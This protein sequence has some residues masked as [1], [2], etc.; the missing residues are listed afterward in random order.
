MNVIRNALTALGAMYVLA[1]CIGAAVPGMNFHVV[2]ADDETALEWHEKLAQRL[3][4][5]VKKEE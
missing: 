1:A 2:L 4:E 5:R 3:R